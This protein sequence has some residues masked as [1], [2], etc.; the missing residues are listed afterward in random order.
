[1]QIAQVQDREGAGTRFEHGHDLMP[2]REAI[3]LDD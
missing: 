3:A 2:H 1:V